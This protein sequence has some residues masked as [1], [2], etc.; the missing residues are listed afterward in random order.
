VKR[1]R[2]LRSLLLAV[3]FSP[4][5]LAAAIAS[6]GAALGAAPLSWS[7]PATIDPGQTLNAIAC[8]SRGLCIAADSAGRVLASTAPASGGSSA[9]KPVASASSAIASLACASMTLCVAVD[10]GGHAIASS[11]PAAAGSWTSP[12]SIDGTT[13]AAIS[14]PS[15]SLCVAVDQLGKALTSTSPAS[16]SQ[17]WAV[18]AIDSGQLNSV[19]CSSTQLCVAVDASGAV[20]ASAQPTGG[21]SAWHKRDVDP[22]GALL[23]VSCDSASACVAVD[24]AGN[25]LASANP[26][27]SA[28]TWS[29]TAIDPSPIG[30][31]A[32]AG[33]S[34]V[35]SKLCVAVDGGE[36]ARASDDPTNPIPVWSDSQASA[37]LDRIACAPE[38]FCAALSGG[39]RVLTATLPAPVATT[40]APIEVGQTTATLAGTVNPND[41]LLGDCRFEYGASA[42]YGQSAPCSPPLT[43]SVAQAVTASVAGLSP[44]AVYHYRLV[45]LSGAGE[46]IG[47]DR[48][49]TTATATLLH[50]HP[51]ISGVPAV[52]SRLICDPGISVS[53]GEPVT[54]TYEW[55]RDGIAIEGAHGLAYRVTRADATHHIQCLVTATNAAGSATGHSAFVAIPAQGVVAAANE[56]VVGRAFAKGTRVSVPIRCS[57]RAARGCAIA[58]RLTSL[59]RDRRRRWASVA[60]GSSSVRLARGQ[61][62]VVSVTLDARGRRVLAHAK[63]LTVQL[64]VSGTVIGL[65]NASLSRQHLTLS[66]PARRRRR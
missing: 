9:W 1:S 42:A 33:V 34:C 39:G 29:S 20:L 23:D 2:A 36:A 57:P 17:P 21:A 3:A 18:A 19:S 8:P 30:A 6:P 11:T 28:P 14:C 64:S 41:A 4:A 38:G 48:T 35:A 45:A 7:A 63:R 51:S 22:A 27:G 37:A 13:V 58:L 46:G 59:L 12:R 65:L 66:R 43:G 5:A 25:A 32:R 31:G 55:K 53:A 47:D 60:L 16:S 61:R 15:E 52:G 49:F 62:Q 56:T 54:L 50:P 40:S 10:T 44:G 26:V 24:G